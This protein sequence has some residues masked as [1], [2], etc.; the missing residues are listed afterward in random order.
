VEGLFGWV[1]DIGDVLGEVFGTDAPGANGGDDVSVGAAE[2]DQPDAVWWPSSGAGGAG[3][4]LDG[5][6][7]MCVSLEGGGGRRRM[8]V[9]DTTW[10]G[11]S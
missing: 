8:L 5:D 9:A 3:V 6:G 10:M 11:H 1:E 4:D 2:T 7:C